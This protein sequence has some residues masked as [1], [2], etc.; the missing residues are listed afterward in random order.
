MVTIAESD[1]TAFQGNPTEKWTTERVV[2]IHHWTSTLLSFRITR[3]PNF[4]FTPGHYARLGLVIDNELVW[5]PYSLVSA[6]DDDHLEFVSVLVPGGVFSTKLEK[7]CVG[8]EIKVDKSCYGFL[9]VDQLAT[10]KD[11]WLLASGTGIGPFVSIL[12]SP[13]LWQAFEHLIVVH[14]VRY[15]VELTY[16]DEIAAIPNEIAF[17]GARARLCYLPVITREPGASELTEHIPLLLMDGRLEQAAAVS[18]SVAT[19]RLMVCGNPQMTHELRQLLS[20]R[21]FVTSRRGIPGQM[22]FEKYW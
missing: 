6:S 12:R 5:R 15:S 4:R 13:A 10:G 8:D 21:G 20:S 7:L 11:L 18:L 9:T 16:R 22:A 19:S 1:L 2:S 3:V 17:A 14:S